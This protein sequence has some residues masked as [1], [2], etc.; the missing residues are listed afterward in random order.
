VAAVLAERNL[1]AG[2]QIYPGVDPGLR[3]LLREADR[4]V[5]KRA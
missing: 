2:V 1:N 5:P 4:T 3:K